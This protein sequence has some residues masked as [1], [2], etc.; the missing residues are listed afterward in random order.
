MML[1]FSLIGIITLI[2][3]LV[4]YVFIFIELLDDGYETKKEFREDLVPFYALYRKFKE[5]YDELS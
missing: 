5:S 3:T 2:F 4:Y 1:T